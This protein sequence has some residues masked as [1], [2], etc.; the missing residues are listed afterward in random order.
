M[1]ELRRGRQPVADIRAHG[2]G[3]EIHGPGGGERER[4]DG[5][6]ELGVHADPLAGPVLVDDALLGTP[7]V[8][9]GPEP[10]GDD[11]GPAGKGGSGKVLAGVARAIAR[12]ARWENATETVPIPG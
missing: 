2:S 12:V 11:L 8:E 1:D 6:A 5:R 3:P 10:V 4:D 9:Q 7:A